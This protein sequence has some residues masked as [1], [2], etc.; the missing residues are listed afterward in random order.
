MSNGFK[1]VGMKIEAE[2]LIEISGLSKGLPHYAHLLS[3]HAGR[4]AI[5]AKSL[6]VG[7]Q[8]VKAAIKLA[9]SGA[10]ESIRNM[11]DKATYSTKKN[12]LHKQVLLACSMTDADERGNFSPAQVEK[13]MTIVMGKKYTIEHFAGH[14]HA[15]CEA[16]RGPVLKKTGLAY[17]FR[18]RF[19]NPL[20]QPYVLMKGLDSGM[21]SE[22]DL[23]LDVD[24]HGQRSMKFT[25]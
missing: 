9:I 16:D 17:R 25:R 8:N 10:Q 19:L 2:A 22:S 5:D 21:V 7:L 23:H 12:A 11:Y 3:L 15:F 1:G 6:R 18:Y 20:L 4:S 24:S 13:P 14:L